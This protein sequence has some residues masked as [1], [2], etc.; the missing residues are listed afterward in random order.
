MIEVV[1]CTPEDAAVAAEGGATQIELC[2]A[3][4]LGGLTPT[5]GLLEQVKA[6]CPLPV[7][8]MLRPRAG[9]FVYS[10]SEFEVMIRDASKLVEAG[11]DGLVFG[12]M[13]PDGMVDQVR[14]RTLVEIADGRD[15]IFHRAFDRAPDQFG[16]LE[17]LIS[18]GFKR[19]LTSGGT[20]SAIDGTDQLM[21][22]DQRAKGR[23][24]VLPGGGI[25]SHNAA[26][27]MTKTGIP[28]LH[29]APFINFGEVKVTDLKTVQQV[30]AVFDQTCE[31]L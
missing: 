20:T 31:N 25:R 26:D 17:T 7:M 14:C 24:E 10:A 2:V 9:D 18:L 4:E 23:I 15:C 27:V 5:L 1:C 21:R 16:A 19:V 3:I 13:Q 28:R 8:A 12:I 30:R 29:L 11:A 6:H 22:L